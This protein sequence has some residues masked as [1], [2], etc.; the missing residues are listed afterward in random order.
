MQRFISKTDLRSLPKEEFD[1]LRSRDVK[2][3]FSYDGGTH[4]SSAT[5]TPDMSVASSGEISD[6]VIDSSSG[7]DR[8]K[9][10]RSGSDSVHV[11]TSSSVNEVFRNSII[12]SFYPHHYLFRFPLK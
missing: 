2:G 1:L 5:S 11:T 4:Y 3:A 12:F 10:N 7:G 9:K 6:G 8:L